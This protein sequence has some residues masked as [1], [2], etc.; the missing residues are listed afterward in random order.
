MSGM[1]EPSSV[2][3]TAVRLIDGRKRLW[4]GTPV[5]LVL[6]GILIYS[7]T[8][9]DEVRLDRLRNQRLRAEG[10][11]LHNYDASGSASLA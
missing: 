4:V 5:L 7:V 8:H 11:I 1:G 10:N 3:F 2:Q 9:R 6:I